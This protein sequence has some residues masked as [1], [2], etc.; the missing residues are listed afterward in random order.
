MISEVKTGVCQNAV[1]TLEEALA[2]AKA[3]EIHNV[4][5]VADNINVG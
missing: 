1:D 5:I 4:A 2:K 3:G